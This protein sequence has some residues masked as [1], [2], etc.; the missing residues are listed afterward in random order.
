[1]DDQRP[2]D[3]SNSS[4]RLW[5]SLALF[6]TAFLLPGMCADWVGLHLA[7]LGFG[8]QLALVGAAIM[9]FL[10][11]VI[12]PMRRELV[13]V[14]VVIG[15]LTLWVGFGID[16]TR[17]NARQLNSRTEAMIRNNELK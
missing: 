11:R 6:A 10:W 12:R 14:A 17:E 2:A 7:Y 5:I 15:L 9:C 1:M 13:V 3:D 4:E 16:R 8:V